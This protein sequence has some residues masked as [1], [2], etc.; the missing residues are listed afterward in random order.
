LNYDDHNLFIAGDTTIGNFT[1]HKLYKNGWVTI[2]CPPNSPPPYFYAPEYWGA[3]RQ[4]NANKKVYLSQNGN[5]SLAY[6]FNLNVSDTLSPSCLYWFNYV[7]SIDSV[8]DG[9]QYHKR[10][11]LSDGNHNNYAALIE[12]IGSTFGAFSFIASPFEAGG[13]LYCVKIN[14]QTVWTYDTTSQCHLF[15]QVEDLNSQIQT[16]LYPN[17]FSVYTILKINTTLKDAKLTMYNTL[18]QK[19]KSIINISG[20]SITLRRDNLP[21]GVYFLILSQ[22]NTIITENKVLIKD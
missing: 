14:D 13:E 6:D 3:F 8:L 21:A 16:F 22:G 15:T 4:D 1:Y 19:M 11:W 17:P 5:E 7:L 18:G 9:S 20:K 2:F 12:G 10:F